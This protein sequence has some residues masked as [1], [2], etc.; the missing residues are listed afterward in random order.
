MDVYSI[1]LVASLV[2]FSL[3]FTATTIVANLTINQKKKNR[4]YIFTLAVIVLSVAAIIWSA[5]M[6]SSYS[7]GLKNSDGMLVSSTVRI[8]TNE[9][10]K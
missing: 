6:Y 1:I 7:G 8:A 4:A 9:T 2:G 10:T 5:A 3:A